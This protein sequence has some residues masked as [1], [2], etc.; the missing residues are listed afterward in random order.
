MELHLFII[1]I[2]SWCWHLLFWWINICQYW[3]WFCIDTFLN[4]DIDIDFEGMNFNLDLGID[5]E[6][7]LLSNVDIEFE[8]IVKINILDIDIGQQYWSCFNLDIGIVM[9]LTLT[10]V[11]ILILMCKTWSCPPLPESTGPNALK[12][13]FGIRF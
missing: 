12:I 1:S 6:F 3:N 8:C 13:S 10:K 5:I 4:V 7:P 9:H 2:N 11:L